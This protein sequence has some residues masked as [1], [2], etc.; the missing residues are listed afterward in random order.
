VQH[1]VGLAETKGAENDRLRLVSASGH[2]SASLVL[3]VEEPFRG[4][5]RFTS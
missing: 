3:R 5:L 1:A 4:F 2:G